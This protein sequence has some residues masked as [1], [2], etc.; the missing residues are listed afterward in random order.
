[1]DDPSVYTLINYSCALSF[2][3]NGLIIN[4]NLKFASM[5]IKTCDD[6]V[7]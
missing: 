7:F 1:M 5:V 6:E 2:N 3:G 4:E